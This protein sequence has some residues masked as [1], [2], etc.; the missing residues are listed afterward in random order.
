MLCCGPGAESTVAP[1]QTVNVTRR[2]SLFEALDELDLQKILA[3]PA[4]RVHLRRWARRFSCIAPIDFLIELC[5]LQAAIESNTIDKVCELRAR[6]AKT[7]LAKDAL[8]SVVDDISD[9]LQRKM[10]DALSSNSVDS[11][12]SIVYQV[13][14]VMLR[15]IRSDILGRFK[16]SEDFKAMRNLHPRYVLMTMQPVRE[17][18]LKTVNQAE[19]DAVLLWHSACGLQEQQAELNRKSDELIRKSAFMD[20]ANSRLEGLGLERASPLHVGMSSKIRSSMRKLQ[21]SA[22]AGFVETYVDFIFGP[23]GRELIL[24]LDP[25]PAEVEVCFDKLSHC[26]R[27]G[28]CSEIGAVSTSDD[29]ANDW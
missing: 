24:E 9:A 4:D 2:T 8:H 3:D 7:Y 16:E 13:R 20:S 28:L 17:A 22:L 14:T 18:F 19:K 1:Q 23:R 29:Y 15:F 26:E 6:I 10:M 25:N 12:R 27:F 5:E 11:A 21:D